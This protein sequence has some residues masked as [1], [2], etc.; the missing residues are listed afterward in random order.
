[1]TIVKLPIPMG[2]GGS[3]TFILFQDLIIMASEYDI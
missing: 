2:D 3:N 1:M